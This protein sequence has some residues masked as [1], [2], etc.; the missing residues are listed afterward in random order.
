M[1]QSAQDDECEVLLQHAGAAAL[2]DD[3]TVVGQSG[4]RPEPYRE[5]T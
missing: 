4:A 1:K 2:P 5:Q 3:K